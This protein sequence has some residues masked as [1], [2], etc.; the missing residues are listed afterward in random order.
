M[1]HFLDG[2]GYLRRLKMTC[3][4]LSTT[5]HPATLLIPNGNRTACPLPSG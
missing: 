3:M 4:R 2:M 5:T 1:L